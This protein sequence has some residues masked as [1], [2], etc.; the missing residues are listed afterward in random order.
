MDLPLRNAPAA[1]AP[2]FPPPA[3]GGG[4]RTGTRGT[5]AALNASV[6]VQPSRSNPR[7]KG[8]FVPDL[9]ARARKLRDT[10]SAGGQSDLSAQRPE[11]KCPRRVGPEQVAQWSFVTSVDPT[12]AGKARAEG[13][14]AAG[15]QLSASTPGAGSLLS[16][17]EVAPSPARRVTTR[18][19]RG[20]GTG[21]ARPG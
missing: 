12:G 1:T 14:Q 2:R 4:T 15:C 19:P 6:R 18:P 3:A 7:E 5:P 13:R 17:S 20:S 8:R 11:A 21:P 9:A 16:Q 10:A